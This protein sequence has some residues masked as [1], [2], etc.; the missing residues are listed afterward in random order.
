MDN[1]KKWIMYECKTCKKHFALLI[2]EVE[3]SEQESQY[4]TCSYNGKH[5]NI[6][7][8]NC[9]ENIEECTRHDSYHRVN[10]RM[11]QKGWSV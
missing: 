6:H 9:Y 2:G 4:I 1:K 7:V 10:G 8:V 5:K 3:H 11:V